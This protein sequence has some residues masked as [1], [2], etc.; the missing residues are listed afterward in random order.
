MWEACLTVCTI[1]IAGRASKRVD[2]FKPLSCL[3]LR[4]GHVQDQTILTG[5]IQ[6]KFILFC[7]NQ[8][9]SSC[10]KINFLADCIMMKCPNLR[11]WMNYWGLELELSKEWPTLLLTAL[12][13]LCCTMEDHFLQPKK[14]NL[15]TWWASWWLHRPF[16]GIYSRIQVPH[17]LA[18]CP[19]HFC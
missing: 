4:H 10:S 19:K 15:G 1:I 16:K 18:P 17:P 11:Q 2:T 8:F 13:W 9:K 14:W 3:N 7:N 5:G 6:K 12:H